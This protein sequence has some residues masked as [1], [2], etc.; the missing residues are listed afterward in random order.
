M[1]YWWFPKGYPSNGLADQGKATARALWKELGLLGNEIKTAQPLLVTSH[2]VD[3][4]LTPHINGRA[5][6]PPAPTP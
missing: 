4:T 6:A 1:G 3:M 2:P 5:L